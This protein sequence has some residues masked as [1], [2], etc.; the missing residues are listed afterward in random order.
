MKVKIDFTKLLCEEY[1]HFWIDEELEMVNWFFST[2]LEGGYEEKRGW[3]RSG[4][5][6]LLYGY[7]AN[8]ENYHSVPFPIGDS[9]GYLRNFI[10]SIFVRAIVSPRSWDGKGK[11]AEWR[12]KNKIGMGKYRFFNFPDITQ[13]DARR[14]LW[15]IANYK[16]KEMKKKYAHPDYPNRTQPKII[17]IKFSTY[18]EG[19]FVEIMF[20]FWQFNY[21]AGWRETIAVQRKGEYIGDFLARAEKKLKVITVNTNSSKRLAFE[22]TNNFQTYSQK[23]CFNCGWQKRDKKQHYCDLMKCYRGIKDCIIYH[24]QNH[25]CDEWVYYDM[26]KTQTEVPPLSDRASAALGVSKK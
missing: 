22:M 16:N 7:S 18:G 26:T 12:T 4:I 6:Q 11:I 10:T 14:L 15:K 2:G 21:E 5:N 3:H 8:N 9:N 1:H 19:Y 20:S 25:C 13:N 23:G 24:I 17:D